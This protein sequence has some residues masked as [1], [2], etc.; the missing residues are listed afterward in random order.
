M[1]AP[2]TF[3]GPRPVRE[4]FVGYIRVS[5]YYEDKIS[6]DI[7]RA[8][9]DAWAQRNNKRIIE[10]VEDL[11]QTGRNFKRR[12]MSAL[13]RVEDREARGIA[14]WRYS[15]FGRSRHGNAMNLARL[16][17][18]GGRLESATEAADTRTA[19]GRLQQGMAFKF[20]E[21]ESDRIGEQWQETRENRLGRGLPATGGQR[22]GYT[23][24]RRRLDDDGT[25]HPELYRPD[26]RLGLVVT[27][28]Y[29]RVAD[30]EPMNSACLW[31]GRQGHL[32]TRGK[33]WKQTGLTRYLDSGFGAGFVRT[34]PEDCDCPPADPEEPSHRAAKCTRRIWLPGAQEP[35]VTEEVWEAFQRRRKEAA[36]KPRSQT[37]A[38]ALSWLVRCARCGGACSIGGS[39]TRGAG[40]VLI[41]KN[42]YVFRCSEHKDSSTCD[43]VYV[44]R[45][46]AEQAVV[47]RLA[48]WADEIEAEAAAIPQQAATGEPDSTAADRADRAK[49][50]LQARLA[51]IETELDRQTSL[52]GRGIIPEDSYTRERDRLQGEQLAV[53]QQI[54]E[55]DEHQADGQNVD[56]AALVPV[57]RGLVERWE[58]TPVATRRNMLRE[59]IRGVWAYP[60]GTGP[61]GEMAETYAVPVPV[62]EPEPEPIGRRADQ[63]APAEA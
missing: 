11:D 43:G 17:H 42:G 22:W 40:G 49:Q 16:E 4:P 19:F 28:L 60:K 45:T 15:R 50:V 14:V 59:L 44:R 41:R 34:H 35:I 56:R 47:E 46:V 5:T 61:K 29:E 38:Y 7:Q 36:S 1:T 32:G 21:F 58:I 10:Y 18:A 8:A 52:V 48:E 13:K 12:I 20:A 30:G 2:A 33:P 25:L 57:M 24:H 6:P 55:L 26:E 27:D 53:T 51:E 23:W 31:L 54:A 63:A 37:P 39:S 3:N 62:W 9:I